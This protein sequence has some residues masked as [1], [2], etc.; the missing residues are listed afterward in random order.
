MGNYL[1]DPDKTFESK[2]ECLK[3]VNQNKNTKEN[4]NISNKKEGISQS[5]KKYETENEI[6]ENPFF[7]F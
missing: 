1:A 3:E 6:E 7:F 5:K 4:K 2:N